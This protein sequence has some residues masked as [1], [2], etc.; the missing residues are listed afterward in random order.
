M[1][2]QPATDK[3]QPAKKFRIGAICMTIWKNSKDGRAWYSATPSR[4]YKQGE[5]WKETDSFGDDDLMNLARLC[6]LAQTWI[7]NQQAAAEPAKAAA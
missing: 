1:T 3:R 7:M 5:E 4:S 6:D 2:D